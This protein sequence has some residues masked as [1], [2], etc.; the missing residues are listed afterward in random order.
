MSVPIELQTIV[1]LFAS[2][3]KQI[4]I[5]ALVD[6]A[7]RLPDP[8]PD[9]VQDLERV[10]ECQS[11]FHVAAVI[12][13]DATPIF[14]FQVPREVSNDARLRRDPPTWPRRPSR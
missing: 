10:R 13:D 9:L 11:P 4:K 3:P 12:D 2:S 8:P 14:Y 7:D 5:E 1:D 6:Y